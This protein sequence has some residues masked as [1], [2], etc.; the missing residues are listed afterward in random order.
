MV[1]AALLAGACVDDPPTY[2][3]GRAILP[4]FAASSARPPLGEIYR[5]QYPLEVNVPFR[6]EDNG[7]PLVA[8]LFLDLPP[9]GP[10]DPARP[11][12]VAFATLSPSNYDNLRRQVI[13]TFSPERDLAGCHSLTLMLTAESNWDTVSVLPNDES[14]V[15]RLVWWLGTDGASLGDCPRGQ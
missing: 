15:A 11:D 7:L 8:L 12:L 4:Y 2:G 9:G 6:S 14:S 5:G 3:A 10:V 13:L 1:V